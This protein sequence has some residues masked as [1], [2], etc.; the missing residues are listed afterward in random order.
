M[1]GQREQLLRELKQLLNASFDL[2]LDEVK[3]EDSLTLT[4]GLTSIQLVTL[5]MQLEE[6][7]GKDVSEQLVAV[8]TVN[9]LLVILEESHEKDFFSR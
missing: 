7:Y 4:Y 8:D 6:T 2:A 9:D 5:A 3:R 1:E